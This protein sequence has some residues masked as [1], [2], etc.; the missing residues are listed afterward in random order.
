MRG[1]CAECYIELAWLW[2]FLVSH[3]ILVKLET[4][5]LELNQLIECNQEHQLNDA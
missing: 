4:K 1:V 2:K 5:L 3:N